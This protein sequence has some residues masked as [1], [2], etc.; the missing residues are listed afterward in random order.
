MNKK[1]KEFKK[2]L[3]DKGKENQ[4]QHNLDKN[5]KVLLI[6]KEKLKKVEISQLKKSSYSKTHFQLLN[7]SASKIQKAYRQYIND[8]RRNK[9][10]KINN[11][12]RKSNGLNHAHQ[13]DG[14]SLGNIQLEKRVIKIQ[15]LG[16]RYLARKAYSN[17]K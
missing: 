4:A 5:K 11:I 12:Q 10:N 9:A 14:R 15:S 6:P 8:K 3:K 7:Y 17:L 1:A 2:A 13:R 16:R